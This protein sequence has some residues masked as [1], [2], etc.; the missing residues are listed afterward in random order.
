VCAYRRANFTAGGKGSSC[1][2]VAAPPARG[3]T[4]HPDLLLAGARP[5]AA[6]PSIR[7]APPAPALAPA[8]G[9]ARVRLLATTVGCAATCPPSPIISQ[10][11]VS[12]WSRV[13][14]TPRFSSG[15]PRPT[16]AG[17]LRRPRV[18]CARNDDGAP[19]RTPARARGRGPRECVPPH[20]PDRPH[21]RERRLSDGGV[22]I[23]RCAL[24]A[25]PTRAWRLTPARR[26]QASRS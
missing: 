20:P 4:L 13:D 23:P 26:V 19:R 2:V 18:E 12:P 6:A 8:H 21:R 22:P 11:R 3:L 7:P 15:R 24:A 1:A 25:R 9:A 17:V 10:A 16:R 5:P 14:R